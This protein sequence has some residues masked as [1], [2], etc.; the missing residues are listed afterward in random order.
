MTTPLQVASVSVS[1]REVVSAPSRKRGFPFPRMTEWTIWARVAPANAAS[2]R[3][4]LAA[5]YRPIGAE[6]LFPRQ[7]PRL[8]ST[9]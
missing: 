9:G 6:V 8:E 2:V 5:G 1:V 7:R 3:A 4:I